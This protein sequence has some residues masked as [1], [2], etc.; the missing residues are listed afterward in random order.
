MFLLSSLVIGPGLLVNTL[1][2]DNWGRAR[3]KQV[4]LF[5]GEASYTPV[6]QI[7]DN[8]ERNCSFVSGEASSAIWLTTLVFLAPR[9]W[10]VPLA[11]GIGGLAVALSLNRVAFGGH[12]LSDTM[13]SW[14]L[15]LTVLFAVYRWLYEAPPAFLKTKA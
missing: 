4:D 15:T 10:R 13:L 11:I 12:F 2:K 5:G 7:S 3:P 1:F 14:L 9:S 8:C 6:W